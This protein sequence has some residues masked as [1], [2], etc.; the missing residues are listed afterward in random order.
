ML[1]NL[2]EVCRKQDQL[3]LLMFE[4]DIGEML[5]GLLTLRGFTIVYY[6]KIVKVELWEFMIVFI[7]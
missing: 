3:Y 2:L 7:C 1:I 4:P 6:E 5:Y